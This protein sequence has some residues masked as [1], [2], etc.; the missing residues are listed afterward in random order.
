MSPLPGAQEDSWQVISSYFEAKGLVRQQL[1]RARGVAGGGRRSPA[2][3]EHASTSCLASGAER[4]RCGGNAAQDSFDEFIQNT[5]Q[6]IVG[7]RALRAPALRRAA[8]SLP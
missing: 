5:M 8:R 4:A 3:N 2:Q 1:V 7:T 6:E